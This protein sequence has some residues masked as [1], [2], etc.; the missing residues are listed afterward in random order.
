MKLAVDSV[1]SSK[2]KAEF[3]SDQER[4]E[5][6]QSEEPTWAPAW[7]RVHHAYT[8]FTWFNDIFVAHVCKAA[9]ASK[10][11]DGKEVEPAARVLGTS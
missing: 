4:E 11:R 10:E 7:V 8:V 3:C 6:G 5:W 1:D 9:C 2:R